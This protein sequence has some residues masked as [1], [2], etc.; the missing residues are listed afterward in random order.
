MSLS[1]H[2]KESELLSVFDVP[3]STFNYHRKKLSTVNIERE[4]LR[5]R[6]K[7]IHEESRESAGSR[8]LSKKFKSEGELVGR[9]KA[10]SLMRETNLVSK[11][12]KTHR[13]RIAKEEAEYA[14]NLLNREFNVDKPNTV[15]CGD[16]TY[17]WSGTCWLY[18]AVVIDLYARR[19]VGWACS[20]HPDSDLTIKALMIAYES[21]GKPKGVLFHS[22]QGC[23]YSSKAFRRRLWRYR[24]IQSMSRRGNCWDNSP[25][26]RF[27]R[28]FKTEWMPKKGYGEYIEAEK[29]I[30]S[31]MK[32]YNGSRL[33]S[34]NHYQSP[35]DA[36]AA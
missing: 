36:E 24:M 32:Y 26:E 3:R 35:I 21:R 20:K 5:Q 30:A 33:H 34:Y 22:D 10:R 29:D 18:L 12:T 14:P 2:Y 31:Y 11:Q 27:F 4:R 8:T 13:Y 17:V 23:H 16:V 1:E 9:Y 7:E 19:V 25:M 28:S 6:A 15:W